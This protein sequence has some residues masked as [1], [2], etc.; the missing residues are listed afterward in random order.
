MTISASSFRA[1]ARKAQTLRWLAKVSG[2]PLSHSANWDH[3]AE[4]GAAAD[5]PGPELRFGIAVYGSSCRV[6][7]LL[8]APWE[9]DDLPGAADQA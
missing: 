7:A 3:K 5:P 2:R 4:P 6:T 9:E 8:S 1:V